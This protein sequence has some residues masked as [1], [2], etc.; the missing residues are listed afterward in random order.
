MKLLTIISHLLLA[1]TVSARNSINFVDGADL[2][3]E[4]T[5]D[6]ED[7]CHSAVV[8]SVDGDTVLFLQAAGG[9]YNKL[10]IRRGFHDGHLRYVTSVAKF[11]K[12]KHLRVC[13]SP[14]NE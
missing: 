13:R 9:S 1:L 7:F 10:R 11:K 8:Y 6:G 14:R 3:V 12:L 4:Y 5:Y 2:S